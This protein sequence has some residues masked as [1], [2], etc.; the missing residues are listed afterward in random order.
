MRAT[1]EHPTSG[2]AAATAWD[3]SLGGMFLETDAPLPEGSLISL[4]IVTAD[5]KVSVDA[6]VLWTRPVNEGAEEP[7]GMNVR[8]IDLPDDVSVALQRALQ[9]GLQER[10]VLG[11]GVAPDAEPAQAAPEPPSTRWKQRR[12]HRCRRHEEGVAGDAARPRATRQP[13]RRDAGAGAGA[14]T[15]AGARSRAH[16]RTR[17][18]A[19]AAEASPRDQRDEPAG[20]PRCGDPRATSG[21]SAADGGR[22]PEPKVSPEPRRARAESTP[23]RE[24]SRPPKSGGRLIGRLVFLLLFGGAFAVVYIYRGTIAQMMGRRRRHRSDARCDAE[25]GALVSVSATASAPPMVDDAREAVETAPADHGREREARARSATGATGTRGAATRGRRTPAAPKRTTRQ[26][27]A[28]TRE[29]RCE[30]SSPLR[31]QKLAAERQ[32]TRLPTGV[33]RE[34]RVP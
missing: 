25:R 29:S 5:A 33:G 27:E 21:G 1:F 16:A 22:A 7:A 18:A 31:A 8:F 30:S 19:P 11:I 23:P 14:S 15:D 9:A 28:L 4:E 20:G 17:T 10:T 6:R 32:A 2:R 13:A 24:P 12:L 34:R 3:A 26:A